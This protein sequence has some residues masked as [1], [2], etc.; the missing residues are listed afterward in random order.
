MTKKFT[1]TDSYWAIELLRNDLLLLIVIG[2]LSFFESDLICS[3]L[4]QCIF[5]ILNKSRLM[6]NRA[7]FIFRLRPSEH[8][9]ITCKK[10]A[11]IRC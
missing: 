8:G 9:T 6:K 11:L 10:R 5:S 1:F 4:G 2:Q 3:D 7:F